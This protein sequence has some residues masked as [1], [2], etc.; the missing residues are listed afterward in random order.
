MDPMT[1]VIA[2]STIMS[3]YAGVQGGATEA[4][5]SRYAAAQST[6]QAQQERAVGQ[7]TALEE[8]RQAEYLASRAQAV[9]ASSG[10]GALDPGVVS[11][12][13]NIKGVGEYK[14]LSAMYEG[15]SRARAYEGQASSSMFRS[16]VQ[17]TSGMVSAFD[18]I[19]RGGST[20][21]GMG[22]K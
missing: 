19:L 10:G 3:S 5:A 18:T 16:G 14:G 7:R 13:S 9:A 11:V 1:A 2:G 15:E 6:Q 4:K 17:T 8:R 12:I 20:L 22:I 21:Y